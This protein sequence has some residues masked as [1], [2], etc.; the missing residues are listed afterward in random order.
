MSF[1]VAENLVLGINLSSLGQQWEYS[2]APLG[3]TF[4]M[5]SGDQNQFLILVMNVSNSLTERPSQP[6]AHPSTHLLCYL[7]SSFL[8][9]SF[10]A[11]F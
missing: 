7:S 1:S 4:Y 9:S 5:D 3:L 10:D 8:T 11:I 2:H 6:I